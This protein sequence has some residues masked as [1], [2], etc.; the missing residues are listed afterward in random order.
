MAS[1]MKIVKDNPNVTNWSFETG[2]GNET[3]KKDYPLRV[4]NSGR[5]AALEI[6][7]NLF[8]KSFERECEASSSQAFDLNL[9]APGEYKYF[10]KFLQ[11]SLLEN[12]AIEI[13]PKLV[14]AS[15]GL[16]KYDPNHRKCFFQSE[17]KLRFYKTYTRSNCEQECIANFTLS[18]C[19][20]VKFSQPSNCEKKSSLCNLSLN[21]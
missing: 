12:T 1:G 5:G 4:Y 3:N 11:L 16:Q 9:H 18:K 15:G 6:S 14:T 2:Y 13:K 21:E 19:G 20:C 10:S 7:L 17:R 8:E